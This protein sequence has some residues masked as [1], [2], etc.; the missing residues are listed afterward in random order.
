ML[1]HLHRLVAMRIIVHY[2]VHF[3]DV[4]IWYRK[5]WWRVTTTTEMMRV[6]LKKSQIGRL[7]GLWLIESLNALNCKLVEVFFF[8]FADITF[9]HIGIII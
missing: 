7:L 9:V 4:L 3:P 2:I 1:H 8:F 5:H 6:I